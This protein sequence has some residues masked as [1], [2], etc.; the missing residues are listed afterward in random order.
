MIITAKGDIIKL[1]VYVKPKGEIAVKVFVV[2][3][4]ESINNLNK[5]WTGWADV[6]LTE[7]GIEDAKEAGKFLGNFSFDK[8]YSSDLKRAVQT[9][10]NAI[11]GCEPETSKLL[12]EINVGSIAN[13]PLGILTEEDKKETREN[14]YI[15]FNG[16]SK[17]EF[18]SRILNFREKLENSQCDNIA[19]FTHGG[20]LRTF[21]DIVAGQRLNR[22]SICCNNCAI[23][24]FEY[25]NKN[26]K[27]HS[28]INLIK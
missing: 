24:I 23:G 6:D 9:A 3:H 13:K 14:G 10:Q 25:E 11:P 27:L 17:D 7:N 22:D 5:Q 12:R 4:G 16:E 1:Q 19:I 15:I 18:K 28:W 2:R 20:W 8:I 26:W 21:L